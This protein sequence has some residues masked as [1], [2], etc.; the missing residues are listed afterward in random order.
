MVDDPSFPS[1]CVDCVSYSQPMAAPSESL[2]DPECLRVEATVMD[3]VTGAR[4]QRICRDMRGDAG[5][6]GYVAR[7]FEAKPVPVEVVTKNVSTPSV[8]LASPST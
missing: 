3:V 4:S 2:P 8:S 6:C 1:A 5:K 7:F